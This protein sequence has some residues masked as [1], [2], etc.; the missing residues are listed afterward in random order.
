MIAS[1]AA[2]ARVAYDSRAHHACSCK[3]QSIAGLATRAV[4]A[5]PNSVAAASGNTTTPSACIRPDAPYSAVSAAMP[6]PTSD[7]AA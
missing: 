6:R 3:R 2:T 4:I 1:N 7:N 5:S